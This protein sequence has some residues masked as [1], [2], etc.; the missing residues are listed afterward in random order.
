MSESDRNPGERV[1]LVDVARA[2]GVSKT[3][4]SDALNGAGRL[5]DATREHVRQV[6]RRLGYRPNATARRLRSGHSRLL[7]LAARE[8]VEHA[9]V[10]TELAYFAQLT[11]ATIRAGTAHG[12]GVVLLP[13]TG[14]DDYWLD[15]PL[16]GVFVVDPVDG[17]PMVGDFLAAGIPVV[18]DR[19]ALAGTP[20]PWIDFDYGGAIRQVLDHLEAAGAERIGA[21]AA[22]TTACFHQDSVQAYSDWHAEKG[23]EPLMVYLDAPGVEAALDAV[24]TLLSGPATPDA[25]VVLVE[26]S[27]PLLLDKL[28]RLGRSV[29]GDLLLVCV[30]ED[31]TTP[32]TDPPVST[33]SFLPAETADVAV[34]MLVDIIERRGVATGR[35]LQ[36]RFDIRASSDPGKSASSAS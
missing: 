15:L 27:P 17:D 25:L 13:T 24:E 28:R 9:W 8:Y 11:T 21:V 7:G 29:P 33:L 12:Y 36:A 6:A 26:V 20:W 23:R 10:Y 2:A 16:D 14:P 4:V 3:T 5:P 19:R 30:T 18:S 1:R 34:E 32:F 22:S 31:T 35:L